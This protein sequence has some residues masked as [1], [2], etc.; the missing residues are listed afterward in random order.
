MNSVIATSRNHSQPA[1]T[2]FDETTSSG[3][4]LT[5]F[6]FRAKRQTQP[7]YT[8]PVEEDHLQQM[9]KRL[10]SDVKATLYSKRIEE[11]DQ[12]SC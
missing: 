2:H 3:K 7:K 11:L 1:Y 10:L 4:P 12:I 5:N 8:G 6:T 9:N